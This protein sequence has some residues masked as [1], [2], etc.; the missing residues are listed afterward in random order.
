LK[1]RL[2]ILL[3]FSIYV[4]TSILAQSTVTSDDVSALVKDLDYN[5]TKKSWVLKEFKSNPEKNLALNPKVNGKGLLTFLNGVAIVIVVGILI[6]IIYLATKD[7]KIK[8]RNKDATTIMALD[9]IVD[10][11]KVD[12]QSLLAE[13]LRMEDYRRAVRIHFLMMLQNLQNKELILWRPNK[14]NRT[15]ARELAQSMY[16]KDFNQLSSIFELALY[17]NAEVRFDSYQRIEAK[18]K[19]VKF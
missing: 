2:I 13:A 18:F 4:Q 16:S 8:S 15:Y 1:I 10:I 5:K 17:G 6:V 19:A 12:F 3:L 7:I 14:T 11:Q 9:D